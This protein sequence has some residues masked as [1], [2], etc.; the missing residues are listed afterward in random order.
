MNHAIR[1]NF[2][3]R[4]MDSGSPLRG[5]PHAPT[6]PLRGPYS[7]IGN[8]VNGSPFGSS[9]SSTSH[10]TNSMPRIRISRKANTS[11]S[12][13]LNLYP[14]QSTETLP[15]QYKPHSLSS[16]NILGHAHNK[17][18]RSMSQPVQRTYSDST[19]LSHVPSIEH[20]MASSNRFALP[21]I[22]STSDSQSPYTQGE[23]KLPTIGFDPYQSTISSPYPGYSP[24][25]IYSINP[26][27]SSYPGLLGQEP[28]TP[29]IVG[30]IR[31][32]EEL[33]IMQIQMNS[34]HP[35]SPRDTTT[36]RV[37][38][39]IL[40]IN[41]ILERRASRPSSPV[42]KLSTSTDTNSTASV[43]SSNNQFV[44]TAP[45]D[46]VI[47]TPKSPILNAIAPNPILPTTG[48]IVDTTFSGNTSPFFSSAPEGQSSNNRSGPLSADGLNSLVAEIPVTLESLS[49]ASE[50]KRVDS[51][52]NTDNGRGSPINRNLGEKRMSPR[53]TVQSG[54]SVTAD[55]IRTPPLVET[56]LINSQPPA[57]PRSRESLDLTNGSVVPVSLPVLPTNTFSPKET[58]DSAVPYLTTRSWQVDD[59][60]PTPHSAPSSQRHRLETL[61]GLTP[62]HTASRPTPPRV[63]TRRSPA[64]LTSILPQVQ[65]PTHLQPI[66]TIGVVSPYKGTPQ[67]LSVS[68][69]PEWTESIVS[70]SE[71][72]TPEFQST[73]SSTSNTTCSSPEGSQCEGVLRTASH[74]TKTPILSTEVAIVPQPQSATLSA[75]QTLPGQRVRPKYALMSPEQ[76]SE[77]HMQFRVKFGILRS[78]NTDMVI[79]DPPESSTLDQKH[80]MYEAYIKQ[81]II[82][83]NCTQWKVYLV[84]S[85]LVI[86]VFVIKVLGLNASGYTKSQLRIINR[87]DQLLA[88]LGEKYYVAG[89]SS[90]PVEARLAGLALMNAVVFI[91]V[92]YLAGYLG[93]GMAETVQD[94]LDNLLMGGISSNTVTQDQYGIPVPPNVS[95]GTN[96]L[97]SSIGQA[98]NP[99]S[100][101]PSSSPQPTVSN[102]S[103]A[104]SQENP[105]SGILSS[106]GGLFGGG[107]GGNG[108]SD[109]AS[110]I[111]NLG[112][113][114]TQN[115][116]TQNNNGNRGSNSKERR[117]RPT[118]PIFRE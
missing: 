5:L 65:P 24:P 80:D 105:L 41:Q 86:E 88:E 37:H 107:A 89:T 57:Y 64:P 38:G 72:N 110:T 96:P 79:I 15:P 60:C 6:I 59:A 91:G 43:I 85:F 73:D 94:G 49:V 61:S 99:P 18:Q 56:V 14:S 42:S 36:L 103:N 22:G 90:W 48:I 9:R 2:S 13:P 21:Q 114:F 35:S 62:P 3:K 63:I 55:G 83:M 7:A 102:S 52:S 87:Y 4:K 117:R 98:M 104:N 67:R 77:M 50:E 46:R 20:L 93:E 28:S 54:E 97:L 101:S 29:S 12:G 10:P 44:V 39:Q 25:S 118:Q 81:I 47:H 111:A 16:T 113:A 58:S 106:L 30:Q 109:I 45:S 84:I 8:E 66:T 108:G 70:D 116:Q 23:I 68:P 82:K 11:V 95:G 75:V 40:D 19:L 53:L 112:T 26:T 32:S 92:K 71:Q 17:G 34:P 69:N 74:I 33:K 115:M 78:S 76:Q 51:T 1:D 31:S 100:C 27:Q